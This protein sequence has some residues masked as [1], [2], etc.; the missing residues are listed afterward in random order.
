[1]T[2][3]GGLRVGACVAH[4]FIALSSECRAQHACCVLSFGELSQCNGTVLYTGGGVTI[5]GA[6]RLLYY[7]CRY[8]DMLMLIGQVDS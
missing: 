6:G 1:M 5:V 2:A 8:D 3:S 7:G 4:L